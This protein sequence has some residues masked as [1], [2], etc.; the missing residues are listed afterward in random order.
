MDR[1]TSGMGSAG[2][3]VGVPDDP[4]LPDAPASG[5]GRV[6][7]ASTRI[8]GPP[9]AGPIPPGEGSGSQSGKGKARHTATK[10]RRWR[11][12]LLIATNVLVAS[13]LILVAAGYG[14]VKY[15]FGS[16]ARVPNLGQVLSGGGKDSPGAPMNVLLVGSD[17]RADISVAEQKAFGKAKDVGGQRADTIMI[18]HIDP[19][20]EKAALL[21]IPRDVAVKVADRG[22]LAKINSAFDGANSA[23]GP[24]RLIKTITQN[25]GIPINHYVEINF[26]GF[27]S[28][29]DAVGGINLNFPYPARDTF[30]GLDI[31]NPGCAH[32]NGGQALSY[33][34]SR[35]LMLK[36]KATGGYREDP[37]A[38]L[39]RIRRQQ[40]FVRIVIQK[41]VSKTKGDP[42][43]LFPLIDSGV[44]NVRIDSGLQ[45]GDI[46]KLAN[47]FRSF[48]A[49]TVDM[50]TLPNYPKADAALGDI[51]VVKRPEAD[52]VI[53]RFN[54]K[55]AAVGDDGSGSTTATTTD[56]S[57]AAPAKVDVRILNGSGKN[58][59]AS[60]VSTS[61][62][63]LGFVIAG[64][65]D[66]D[67]PKS[68]RNVIRYAPG[69][70]D[71]AKLLQTYLSKGA[72]LK[73]DA[74]IIGADVVFVTGTDLGTIR[75]PAGAQP[76]TGTKKTT[77]TA[78]PSQTS[79]PPPST[80]TT[81]PFTSQTAC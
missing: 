63:Q 27:Q 10:P 39:G 68:S 13:T 74:T 31:K 45:I 25:F 65:G 18:L 81:T 66:T 61:L 24:A 49:D 44:S 75:A 59:E 76:A 57:P 20:E 51:L 80:S 17:S 6:R 71:K 60:R 41:A 21:S 26:D 33:A 22:G 38:D 9:A 29:V 28:I 64:T 69:A 30:T 73:E 34:R 62:L 58:G 35:H 46:R 36:L 67:V 48:N 70:I 32:L 1:D 19:G 14:Y 23:D 15:K 11:R 3:F 78:G 54:S 52:Q 43:T 55:G 79:V 50:M 8:A 37:T 72:T 53:S 12:R 5:A 16:I 4:R 7:L 40:D 42:T 77:T 56:A 2:T 47:R